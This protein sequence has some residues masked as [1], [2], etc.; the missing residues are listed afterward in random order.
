MDPTSPSAIPLAVLVESIPTTLGPALI[1]LVLNWALLGILTTQVYVYY[2]C[3][4]KDATHIKLL[5]Y[6]LFI[7]ELVQSCLLMDDNWSW[8]ISS[9]KQPDLILDF[10]LSWF[11]VPVMTAV[12]SCGVQV[13][14][15]WRVYVLGNS[16]IVPGLISLLALLQCSA[17][18]ASGV[19]DVK[20]QTFLKVPTNFI[21]FDLWLG[22]SA[23]VDVIIALAMT[24][25]LLKKRSFF[26]E[27]QVLL[28]RL[29]RLSIET[30]SVTAVL[31]IIDIALF[32]GFK[33][34]QYFIVPSS[35]LAKM[36]SNTLLV[37]LN[38]RLYLRDDSS[39]MLQNA[40]G[41][42]ST[43]SSSQRKFVQALS[44]TTITD[45]VDTRVGTDT[46]HHGMESIHLNSLAMDDSV[47]KSD[48]GK[49]VVWIER[50]VHMV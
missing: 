24:Y 32:Y 31:A 13:F 49:P 41:T 40:R 34:K 37:S 48:Q 20:I 16:F 2:L 6:G 1:G 46:K 9:W 43:G 3:F 25:Y 35:I 28:S 19:R 45:S 10:H 14:F 4:P 42:T 44:R 17:G 5:V 39:S 29:V 27:T 47:H 23:S 15:A 22:V 12:I 21:E 50:D 30:G 26:H 18:I 7:T 38:A 11:E 33:G 36:Y 8:L